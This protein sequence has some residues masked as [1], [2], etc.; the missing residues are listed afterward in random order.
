MATRALR[1]LT[2]F[3]CIAER[4]EDSCCVAT[5]V[6]VS[7]REYAELAA[8]LGHEVV[9]KKIPLNGLPRRVLEYARLGRGNG[10][11]CAFLDVDRLCSIQKRHGAGA[12]PE[13][14]AAFPRSLLAGRSGLELTATAACPEI[15]R[16][17]VLGEDP[18]E[19]VDAPD[20]MVPA[21][22]REKARS[23]IA[24]MG[25]AP[26]VDEVLSLLLSGATLAQKLADLARIAEAATEGA[27]TPAP[28]GPPEL[29]PAAVFT[30]LF[31]R[32]LCFPVAER[33]RAFATALL[34]QT[35]EHANPLAAYSTARAKI[36]DPAK[37]DLY[38]SRYAANTWTVLRFVTAGPPAALAFALAFRAAA[39]RFALVLH[40]AGS[41]VPLADSAIH[42]IQIFTRSLEKH[43]VLLDAVNERAG[44]SPLADLRALAAFCAP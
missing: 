29:D 44:L 42:A 24:R 28:P 43:P 1:Y 33:S 19:F 23:A 17:V 41:G 26:W 37:L 34:Q 7:R 3:R 36:E 38:V 35:H 5:H 40:A 20:E 22:W 31:R 25:T 6:A 18:L 10:A 30:G 13:I 15:A 8:T 21:F 9:A 2:R 39:V 32:R 12:L 4:C 11:D 27:P 14:C 16:L